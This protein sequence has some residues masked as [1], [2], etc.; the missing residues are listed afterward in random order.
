[1]DILWLKEQIRYLCIKSMWVL[2]HVLFLSSE[3]KVFIRKAIKRKWL[4]M[5]LC[6]YV[7][8]VAANFGQG[9]CCTGCLFVKEIYTFQK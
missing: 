4:H 6:V 5:L 9:H 8:K 3:G 7:L 2:I 1:M